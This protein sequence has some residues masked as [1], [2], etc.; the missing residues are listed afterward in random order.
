MTHETLQTAFYALSTLTTLT[1]TIASVAAALHSWHNRQQIHTI[2]IE[3]NHRLS[4]LLE[5]TGAEQRAAGKVE[6]L[7]ERR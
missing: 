7:A 1:S 2:Q 5:S 4:Q 6:G 3:L